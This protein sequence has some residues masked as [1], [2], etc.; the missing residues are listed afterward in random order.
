[1]ISMP[2]GLPGKEGRD[3]M[4]R[5]PRQHLPL[6]AQGHHGDKDTMTSQRDFSVRTHRVWPAYRSSPEHPLQTITVQQTIQAGRSHSEG[7]PVDSYHPLLNI[8]PLS[9]LTI[10]Q[11]SL[12]PVPLPSV[13]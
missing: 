11:Q 10:S 4:S 6:L 9:T 5:S 2:P 8:P 3:T 12:Y 7:Q 1:M 13:P